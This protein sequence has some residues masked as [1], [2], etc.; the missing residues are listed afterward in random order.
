M[1]IW[2]PTIVICSIHPRLGNFNDQKL[3]I[4]PP[5]AFGENNGEQSEDQAS[6]K[7]SSKGM[8]FVICGDSFCQV[9]VKS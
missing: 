5:K 7:N 4:N 3:V 2:Q 9:N 6:Q 1:L 8:I